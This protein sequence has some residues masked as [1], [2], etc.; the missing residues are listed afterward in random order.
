[1]RLP[2]HSAYER[3]ILRHLQQKRRKAQRSGDTEQVEKLANILGNAN[4]FQVLCE[5]IISDSE[6][7]TSDLD[8]SFY[9]TGEYGVISGL[10]LLFG[11]LAT[12]WSSVLKM[13]D[14]IIDRFSEFSE[15]SEFSA[16][17]T[18]LSTTN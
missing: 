13:I 4:A 5:Q 16:D 1:M 8:T 14:A 3:R 15:F 2:T 9:G 11:W 6:A 17:G 18:T 10:L 7:P 12:N